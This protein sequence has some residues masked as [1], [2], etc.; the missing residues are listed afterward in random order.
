MFD[1]FRQLHGPNLNGGKS[2]AIAHKNN[3]KINK[4]NDETVNLPRLPRITPVGCQVNARTAVR[5]GHPEWGRVRRAGGRQLAS[6]TRG[7]RRG[8][9]VRLRRRIRCAVS[10]SRSRARVRPSSEHRSVRGSFTVRFY[11]RRLRAIVIVVFF[12]FGFL[13]ANNSRRRRHNIRLRSAEI[14]RSENARAP[15]PNT[16]PSLGSERTI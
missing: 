16:P 5:H 3:K 10:R 12:Y 13:S 1:F 9:S 8:R 15:G 6:G 11:L 4:N 7:T 2:T 14:Q